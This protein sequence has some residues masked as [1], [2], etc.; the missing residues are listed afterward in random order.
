MEK[1][2][3]GVAVVCPELASDGVLSEPLAL[4]EPCGASIIRFPFL[5][6]PESFSYKAEAPTK[7]N[8]SAAATHSQIIIFFILHLT[9][10]E[11]IKN[12]VDKSRHHKNAYDAQNN[13][14]NGVYN[15]VVALYPAKS[16]AELVDKHGTQHKGYAKARRIA[17]K[18]KDTFKNVPLL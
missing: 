2:G 9:S 1:F 13:A 12:S 18:Q 7:N 16:D 6:S 3:A 10:V 11:H 17:K 4:C 14:A 8:T 5:F 15:V